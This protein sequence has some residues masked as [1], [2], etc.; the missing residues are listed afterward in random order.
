M[1]HSS[2]PSQP[3]V[4]PTEDAESARSGV[5]KGFPKILNTQKQ[6]TKSEGKLRQKSALMW[7][8]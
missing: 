4:V 6:Q 8:F 1:K 2:T 7:T 3:L 5:S